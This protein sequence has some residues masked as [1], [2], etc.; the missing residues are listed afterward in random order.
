LCLKTAGFALSAFASAEAFLETFD[1]RNVVCILLDVRLPGMS[2]L[3]LWQIVRGRYPAIPV[4]LLTGHADVPLAVQAVKEGVVD[5]LEKPVQTQALLERL[6]KAAALHE[7]LSARELERSR[8]R[9][10][11]ARLT[12]R[13]REV[14]DLMVSGLKNSEIAQRLGISTK[15]LDI[16]RSKVMKKMEAHTIADLVRWRLLASDPV[17]DVQG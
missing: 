13:Q 7:E 9:K 5:V 4:I 16:H 17:Q 12:E 6:H 15:T 14:L 8:V 10:R 2:G 11:L 1:S 3:D